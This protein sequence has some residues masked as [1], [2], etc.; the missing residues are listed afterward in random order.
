MLERCAGGAVPRG[1]R[2]RARKIALYL[3]GAAG[4]GRSQMQLATH[5]A[6]SCASELPGARPAACSSPNAINF[7]GA[8]TRQ[9]TSSRGRVLTQ[10]AK[11]ARGRPERAVRGHGHE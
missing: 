4:A 10:D 5:T 8:S 6:I 3:Q 7:A 1:R 2:A 11:P 9:R